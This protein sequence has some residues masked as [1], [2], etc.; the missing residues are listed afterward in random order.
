[1]MHFV[2]A[3]PTKPEGLYLHRIGWLDPLVT[4]RSATITVHDELK[5]RAPPR[6]ISKHVFDRRV[7]FFPFGRLWAVA[8]DTLEPFDGLPRGA[9]IHA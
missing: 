8:L 9:A 6:A 1:M 2:M 5:F 4:G 3:L 7:E